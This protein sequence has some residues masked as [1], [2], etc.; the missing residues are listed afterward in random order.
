M[1]HQ[2]HHSINLF[3]SNLINPEFAIEIFSI[4]LC[5]FKTFRKCLLIQLRRK[6]SLKNV[7]MF[8][9]VYFILLCLLV[10]VIFDFPLNYNE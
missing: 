8:L 3:L 7:F 1:T 4:F 6:Q 2:A 10:T 9:T 5:Q